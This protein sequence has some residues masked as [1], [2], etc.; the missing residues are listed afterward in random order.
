M[1][2]GRSFRYASKLKSDFQSANRWLLSPACPYSAGAWWSYSS[3]LCGRSSKSHG[4]VNGT[5]STRGLFTLLHNQH[6]QRLRRSARE[7]TSVE[8]ADAPELTVQS[9]AMAALQLR[10]VETALGKLALEQRQVI[11]LVGLEGLAYEEVAAC[12]NAGL[13]LVTNSC[14]DAGPSMTWRFDMKIRDVM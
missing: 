2:V 7:G 13:P 1:N 10:D 3:W 11:L 8:L 12:P 9:N 5:A 14:P 4:S 6:V